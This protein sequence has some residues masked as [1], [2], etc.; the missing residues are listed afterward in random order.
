MHAVL[1][2]GVFC[3]FLVRSVPFCPLSDA[4]HLEKRPYTTF[5]DG[6]FLTLLP[7]H[8]NRLIV[9]RNIQMDIDRRGHVH[10]GL[11]VVCLLSLGPPSGRF[12][13]RELAI[14]VD[15]AFINS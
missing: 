3:Q 8:L 1:D 15:F 9:R 6:R 10:V 14:V 13:L 4:R 5:F 11:V 12:L 7:V 2:R